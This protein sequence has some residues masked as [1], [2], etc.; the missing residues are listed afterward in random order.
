M[1]R[2]V[3]ELT[4]QRKKLM[5]N[6]V[7]SKMTAIKEIIARHIPVA[8]VLPRVPSNLSENVFN[9]GM[10]VTPGKRS[11]NEGKSSSPS[12]THAQTMV[13]KEKTYAIFMCIDF[14]LISDNGMI[15]LTK[16]MN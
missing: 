1:R 15:G 11:L 4:A 9:S 6:S 2:S 16:L 14:V 5:T 3:A 13:I 8:Q 7:I 10:F 12:T